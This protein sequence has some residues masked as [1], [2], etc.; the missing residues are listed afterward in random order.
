MANE[1]DPA[2]TGRNKE[3][4]G[5]GGRRAGWEG[6]SRAS[7]VGW[8]DQRVVQGTLARRK[9]KGGRIGQCTPVTGA[10]PSL[11]CCV[12]STGSAASTPVYEI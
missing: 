7:V 2:H 5:G 10:A 3:R 12:R 6:G 4:V 1:K 8:L 11:L 9:R